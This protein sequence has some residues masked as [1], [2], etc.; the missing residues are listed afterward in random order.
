MK[1]LP[2]SIKLIKKS[3]RFCSNHEKGNYQHEQSVSAGVAVEGRE[4]GARRHCTVRL[5]VRKRS[6]VGAVVGGVVSL[7]EL[8][9]GE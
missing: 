6:R 8:V 7:A 5:C 1:D 3:N 4:V 9:L 2:T